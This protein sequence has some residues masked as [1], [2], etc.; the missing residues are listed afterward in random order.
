MSLHS[1]LRWIAASTLVL[2]ACAHE[3]P[4]QEFSDTA[5]PSEEVAKLSSDIDQGHADQLNVLSPRHFQAASEKYM[6]A[7]ASLD[8]GRS[9]RE[10]LHQVALARAHLDMARHAAETAQ[11]AMAEVSAARSRAMRAQAPRY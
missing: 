3:P 1:T 7:K 4:V 6:D 9:P 10:T 11:D 8:H 2:A 5:N